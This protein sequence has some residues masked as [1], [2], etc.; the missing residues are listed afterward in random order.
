MPMEKPPSQAATSCTPLTTFVQTDSNTFREVVQRLTGPSES[1]AA[2]EGAGTKGPGL[3]RPTSKLHERRQYMRPKLEIVKP[4][5]SFKP[6]TSPSRSGSSC[7]LTSP[8]GTPSTVFSKLS[9][10]EE[11]NIEESPES[12]LNTE[13]EEKAIK[14]RRFYL[15]PSPRSRTGKMEPELLSLFPL[16]SPR[17]NDK[18]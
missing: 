12:D 6:A 8:V 1:D 18:A 10:L 4:P 16:T 13:E 2:E 9:L 3:K 5:L 11:E 14:E 7:L 17:T 15:H